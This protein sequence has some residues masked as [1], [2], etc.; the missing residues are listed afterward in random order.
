M[1][2]AAA[3]ENGSR[4]QAL[5]ALQR[6]VQI[7]PNQAPAWQV[8][9]HIQIIFII[10]IINIYSNI[11]VFTLKGLAQLHEKSNSY[12]DLISVYSELRKIFKTD[13][14]KYYDFSMKYTNVLAL[15]G[16]KSEV[17]TYISVLKLKRN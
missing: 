7:S 12:S 16:K 14:N 17:F 5:A 8:I 10:I 6:A 3:Q 1:T 15:H 13:V 11:F 2:G 9:Q 4:D